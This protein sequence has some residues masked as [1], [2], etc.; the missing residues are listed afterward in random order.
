[1][2]LLVAVAFVVALVAAGIFFVSQGLNRA[3]QFAGIGAFLL[4]LLVA[5]FTALNAL[6]RQPSK[7]SEAVTKD[8]NTVTKSGVV[9]MGPNATV[10]TVINKPRWR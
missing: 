7:D 4:A 1:M 6:R 10:Q 3:D 9:S 5:G 2:K 8:G